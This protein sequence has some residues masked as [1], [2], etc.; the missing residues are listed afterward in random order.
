MVGAALLALVGADLQI[1]TVNP[2]QE[3]SRIA[4]GVVQPSWDDFPSLLQA[5]AHTVSFALLAVALAAPLGLL[6]AMVFHWLPVRLLCA[7][8]RSVHELFWGLIFMQLF[9]LSATTGLLAILV[10]FTGMFAKVFAEIFEQQPREP[11]Q[12]LPPAIGALKR[13]SYTLIPQS[14]PALLSYTRYRFECALR[15]S[16]ILGFIGLPTLG[17]HLETAFKQGQYSE[18]GAL[19]WVF[20]LLIATIRFWLRPRL[21]PLYL[22]MAIWFLPETIG[23]ST[24]GSV[25]RFI[26]V[27]IWPTALRQGDWTGLLDWC[28]MM[29]SGQVWPGLV[30]T[31]LLTQVALVLSGLVVLATYPLASRA[32]AGPVVCWPGRFL[33]LVLRSTPEMVMAYVL[34]LL[35]GPSGLPVVLAL[36]LHNGGLIAFLVANASDADHNSPLSRPDD[37]KGIK[38]YA[39]VETPRR[40]PAMLAFLFYRWEV[41]LRESA[42]MGILGVATLGFYIDSAFEEI[43]Y[44]RAFLLI[45]VTALLN[46]LVDS[47]SRRLRQLANTHGLKQKKDSSGKCY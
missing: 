26:S 41:I 35:C 17:F 28:R 31:L 1:Y 39:Y 47:L 43:R 29:F 30:Q 10:P 24:G 25:W 37:P 36:G 5:L 8:V 45:A 38:R 44:D 4:M 18:A 46:I 13:Y 27:D 16:A 7:S 19:L 15:S 33:L 6:L 21:L 2:W 3:L 32:L 23:F 34:L 11:K 14:C 20:L 42:I 22:L 40:F 12:T 9:G